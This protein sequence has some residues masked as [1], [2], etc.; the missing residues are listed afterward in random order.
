[1]GGGGTSGNTTTTVRFAPYVE[2][3]HNEF[4]F[5]V[6]RA[7]GR[8][9]NKS[10]YKNY[11]DI[12]VEN[13]FFNSGYTIK[14]F[15]GMFNMYKYHMLET[16]IGKLYDKIF[17]DS[18]EGPIITDMIAV[19]AQT[20][21]DDI[22]TTADPRFSVGARDLNAVMSSSFIV[23]RSL[24][25]NTRIKAMAKFSA[26]VRFKMITATLDKWKTQ[27][28]WSRERAHG[29][30]EMM[31]FYLSSKMDVDN[32]NTEIHAKNELWEFSV[33]SYQGRALGIL[34]GAKDTSTAVQG[35]SRTNKVI[36]SALSGAAAG[37]MYGAT[38]GSMVSPGWG[39]AIGTVLGAA[40]G[41]FN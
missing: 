22:T 23:G 39:T 20:L 35:A 36:G 31:K 24:M 26:E 28:S 27:L 10:P 19:E 18:T 11:T 13:T 17:L 5:G 25:E 21:S 6:S 40:I 34:T 7:V 8:H 1:M 15:P 16:D 30:A 41:L 37:A 29:Y 14:S 9:Q 3:K 32:H 33:L 38:E 2:A 12:D 4:I